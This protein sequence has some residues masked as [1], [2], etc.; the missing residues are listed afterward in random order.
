M[1]RNDPDPLKLPGRIAQQEDGK[2]DRRWVEISNDKSENVS[3]NEAA[4]KCFNEGSL[5]SG[6]KRM[7]YA[8]LIAVLVI[9]VVT[10][11]LRWI[12]G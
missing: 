7:V 9:L 11:V 6:Y 8:I 12:S 10:A 5:A 2:F 1:L 3:K 4:D